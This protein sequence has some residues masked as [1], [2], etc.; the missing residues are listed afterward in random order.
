MSEEH[1]TR[2]F[3]N[4]EIKESPALQVFKTPEDALKG[5]LDLKAWQGRA[6]SLPG[7]DAKPEDI[8]AFVEKAGKRVPGLVVMPKTESPED[9]ARFWRDLGT[10]EDPDGYQPPADIEAVD[11]GFVKELKNFAHHAGM[12]NDQFGKFLGKFAE[13]QGAIAEQQ[14]QQ[15]QENEAKL[16]QAWGNAYEQNIAI[17]DKLLEEFTDGNVKPGNVD[18]GTRLMLANIAKSLSS[19]PQV[20]RQFSQDNMKKSPSELRI[21]QEDLFKK[22]NDRT[23]TGERRKQLLKKYTSNFD[24][25]SRYA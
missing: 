25:L 13:A 5:Y 20:T 22:L 6:V 3:E 21:E 10:P 2:Q 24:E 19:D 4:P 18:N 14:Q 23:I 7:E 9:V 17:T 16:K 1:W 8:S 11:E 15:A 12:T